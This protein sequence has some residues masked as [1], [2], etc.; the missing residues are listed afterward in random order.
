MLT[1]E[2]HILATLAKAFIWNIA[3]D[4]CS[5]FKHGRLHT[6]DVEDNQHNDPESTCIRYLVVKASGCVGGMEE[7]TN[8]FKKIALM[9][10]QNIE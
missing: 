10:K 9:R 1:F 6:A 8:V 5:F 7:G 4:F 2:A 3:T